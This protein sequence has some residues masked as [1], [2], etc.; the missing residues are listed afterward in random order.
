MSRLSALGALSVALVVSPVASAVAVDPSVDPVI[1][2]AEQV[3]VE[4]VTVNGVGCQ[5]G[6]VAVWMQPDNQAIAVHFSVFMVE[7]GLDVNRTRVSCQLGLVVHAPEGYAFGVA[8]AR[9]QGYA[10]LA[11]GASGWVQE[12]HYLRGETPAPAVR[13]TLTGPMED[14]W[15]YVDQAPADSVAF[16]SCG[17]PSELFL[18]T[19]MRVVAGTSPRGT[20]NFMYRDSA[21]IYPSSSYHLTWR[22]CP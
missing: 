19:Q 16:S 13:H 21:D 7:T 6:T 14:D 2:P 12:T 18:N 15:E 9:H 10:E 8:G 17:V 3:T 4:V 22:V 11:E 20:S 1:V 5:Q